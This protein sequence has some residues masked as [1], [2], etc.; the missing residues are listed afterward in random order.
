MLIRYALL[1]LGIENFSITDVHLLALRRSLFQKC[2][3]EFNQTAE[4]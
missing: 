2:P 4:A 1:S 3:T